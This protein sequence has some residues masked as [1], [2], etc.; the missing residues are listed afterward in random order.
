VFVVRYY[1]GYEMDDI[2]AGTCETLGLCKCI[3]SERIVCRTSENVTSLR[4][5]P[6]DVEVRKH[7]L[8]SEA[9]FPSI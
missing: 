6:L 8:F 1:W 7:V 3:R 2:A 4:V 5:T 9:V